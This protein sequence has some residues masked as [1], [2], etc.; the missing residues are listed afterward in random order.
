MIAQLGNH[1]SEVL[2]KG[3]QTFVVRA[4]GLCASYLF[5]ILLAR[6][7]GAEGLGAYSLGLSVV[8]VATVFGYIGMHQVVMRLVA[9]ADYERKSLHDTSLII[10]V[11]SSS[12]VA[13]ALFSSS[14]FLSTVVFDKPQIVQPLRWLS[15][16]IIPYSILRLYVGLLKGVR[17][18]FVAAISESISIQLIALILL[19]VLPGHRTVNQV[20]M[21]YSI[22][23]IATCIFAAFFW[24]IKM[25]RGRE[26]GKVAPQMLLWI[27]LPLFVVDL[28]IQLRNRI[29]VIMLGIWS[30]DADVGIYNVALRTTLVM[31]FLLVSMDAILSPKFAQLYAANDMKSLQRLVNQ[32]V[33]LVAL[34]ACPLIVLFLVF[35]GSLLMLFGSEFTV[36]AMTMRIVAVGVFFQIL[37]G[38]TAPLLVMTGNETVL[39]NIMMFSVIFSVIANFL[40]IPT[41]GLRGAAVGTAL[42]MFVQNSV[43]MAAVSRFTSIKMW[44][45]S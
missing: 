36:G 20:S 17:H 9:T 19:I 4:F 25:D 18:T 11:I 41:F 35:P 39:R 43:S 38:P 32:S 26:K 7:L 6:M 28:S 1:F 10:V 33:R 29:D 42:T 16:S 23:V 34:L 45:I 3:G 14:S 13:V 40:L 37:S 44:Q 8:S 21:I 31:G 2:L 30:S 5:N 27:A 12:V 15:A 24:N 22:A